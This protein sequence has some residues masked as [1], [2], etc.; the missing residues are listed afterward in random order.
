ME[1]A[2]PKVHL[3]GA[4]HA[5]ISDRGRVVAIGVFDGMHIGHQA[6]LQ[7][8]IHTA[9]VHNLDSCAYTFDPHPLALLRP[10]HAPIMLESISTRIQRLTNLGIT[11]VIVEPF[12]QNLANT[13]PENF[14]Q[15]ILH[16]Q[17]QAKH[18]VVGDGFRF[19]NKQRGD[20]A[21]L[22]LCAEQYNIHVH[23]I[24]HAMIDHEK[25]SSSRIRQA[26]A[27]AD[28]S[29]ARKLL[30]RYPRMHGIIVHGRHQ[31]ARLGFPTANLKTDVPVILPR[32][33]Y[34]AQCH[35]SFGTRI[36]AVNIGFAPTLHDHRFQV[37][38]HLLD[39]ESGS[40]YGESMSIDFALKIR[41]EISFPNIEALKHQISTDIACIRRF[42]S[43]E[44]SCNVTL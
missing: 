32:G 20:L 26:L 43:K 30:G 8:A 9:S 35:G 24:H 33:V 19:G 23:A 17:L 34:A 5:P 28:L 12:T 22:R 25:V 10:D 31:G 29:F 41:D 21:L 1:T 42:W 6:L 37:E 15:H 38:A 4:A 36:A 13:S 16:E 3:H 40:L 14:V 11:T 2:S 44:I 7:H 18:I 27:N 39:H